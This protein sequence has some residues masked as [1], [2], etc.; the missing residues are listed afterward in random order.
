MATRTDRLA[1]ETLKKTTVT[2][3]QHRQ[4][5]KPSR[6]RFS[7]KTFKACRELASREDAGGVC[8]LAKR[9]HPTTIAVGSRS[10]HGKNSAGITVR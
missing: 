6:E 9:F 8:S 5:R 2:T 10:D 7:M 3:I 4:K 1:G